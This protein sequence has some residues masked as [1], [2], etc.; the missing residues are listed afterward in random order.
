MNHRS[1]ANALGLIFLSYFGTGCR[2]AHLHAA[3]RPGVRELT[4]PTPTRALSPH[5]TAMRE[6]SVLLT[7]LEPSNEKLAPVA[8][9]VLLRRSLV[10]SDIFK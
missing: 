6:G 5:V 7:W 2:S 8:L 10:R 1:I 4:W 3:T 9:L